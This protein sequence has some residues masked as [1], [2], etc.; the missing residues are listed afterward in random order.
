LGK[1]L[2]ASLSMDFI[3]TGRDFSVSRFLDL[4]RR[5]YREGLDHLSVYPLVIEERTVSALRKAQNRTQEDLEE[6]AG[7]NW[8]E[9]C[10]GLSGA[11]WIRY[12]VSNFSREENGACLYNLHVWKGGDYLGLGTGAHQKRNRI[13]T[14]NVRSI[15]DYVRISGER[16]EHPYE[17]KEKISSYD[18]DVEFLYTNLRLRE[19]LP[20]DWLLSR[21]EK[22]SVVRM[23]DRIVREGGADR[24]RTEEGVLVLSEKGLF[25]QDEI[26]RSLLDCFKQSRILN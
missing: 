18:S 25:M 15:H 10:R 13:R 9:V 22:S 17:V 12:E 23:I 14:E 26:A 21:T 5:L 11:G 20:L 19:G 2:D 8:R 3:C 7:E 24:G 4:A 1:V 6:T 16:N